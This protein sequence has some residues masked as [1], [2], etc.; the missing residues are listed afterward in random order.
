MTVFWPG[1]LP[2]VPLV[3]GNSETALRPKASFDTEIGPPIVRRRGTVKISKMPVQMAMTKQQAQ[4]FEAFVDD[5][6]GGG[7]LPFYF[8]H[9]RKERQ[10]T[11]WI[12]GDEPYQFEWI[13]F[14]FIRVSFTLRVIE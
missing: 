6:I 8:Q 14:D 10:I 13:S 12:E 4:T 11:A 2:Q 9:P 5:E 3:D 1:S 7:S